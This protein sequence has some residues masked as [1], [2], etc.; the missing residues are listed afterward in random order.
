MRSP[1]VVTSIGELREVLDAR[2]CAGH[3]VGFVPTM[4]YL[5][6]G[7]A[8]L[9]KASVA[10]CDVN[11]VSIF[12]N[13]LQFA[14]NE[15]LSR[16]PRD[17]DRDLDL[18]GRSG[19]DL[20][21]VPT[22]EEMYPSE[23]LTVVSVSSISSRFE[24]TNRPTH[25]SGVATVVTKLFSMVG[26]CTA[27]FGEKDFQQLAI[28]KKLVADL[29][30]P[31]AVVGCPTIREPDGLAMSSRN[32]YL[33]ETERAAASVLSRALRRGVDLIRSSQTV[34]SVV[35]SA[36]AQVV[37]AESLCELDYAAVVDSTSLE[38]FE[39]IPEN[40]RLLIAARFSKAR[41]IDNMG[42]NDA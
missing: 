8:S 4:G 5:H 12:V 29:S 33:S 38:T 21:F 9:V 10:A 41:L 3:S 18:C 15:D 11:V 7:H 23:V 36:M 16:Y 25:F 22:D 42:V 1:T 2:R 14:P 17:L 30:M 27:F 19:A 13:P 24:G 26:S 6:A 20:V 28:V 37:A 40:P 34:T 31:V 39:T 32:V 35:E